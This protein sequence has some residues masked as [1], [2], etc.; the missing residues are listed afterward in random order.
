MELTS[1]KVSVQASG[2]HVTYER[3]Q[4]RVLGTVA[5]LTR[6]GPNPGS[7]DNNNFHS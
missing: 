6:G 5:E 2:A 4:I 3:P 7:N 1:K